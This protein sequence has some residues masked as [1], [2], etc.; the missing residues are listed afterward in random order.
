MSVSSILSCGRTAE[1]ICEEL[2]SFSL[3][4]LVEE[5]RQKRRIISNFVP[6]IKAHKGKI[7]TI[8]RD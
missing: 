2:S 7:K 5:G 6:L 1:S 3:K 4:V 8:P